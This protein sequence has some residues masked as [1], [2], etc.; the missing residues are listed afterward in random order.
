[1]CDE[2]RLHG[3]GLTENHE[4]LWLGRNSTGVSGLASVVDGTPGVAQVE[5]ATVG[6][7]ST[8]AGDLIIMVTSGG[9]TADPVNVAL[10]G[11]ESANMIV[12]KIAETVTVTGYNITASNGKVILTK[13]VP[14]EN[15]TTLNFAINGS[16][17]HTGVPDAPIS[18]NTTTGVAPT[19]EVV[20]LAIS[21]GAT[22]AGNVIVT[23]NDT[24]TTVAVAAGDTQ[25][26]VAAKIGALLTVAGYNV[27]VSNR[28][29]V[30]TSTTTGNLPDLRVTLD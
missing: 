19:A 30:F 10:D 5:T 26:Q 6:S 29:V 17:N 27:T 25:E 18:A 22:N 24:P 13:Q 11:T 20:T 28:D 15:D 12:N 16:T 9:V 8:A 23:V 21:S 2:S 7:W 3:V 4:V 14:A 1:M